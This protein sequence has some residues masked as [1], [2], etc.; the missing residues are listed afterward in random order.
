[1]FAS[2]LHSTPPY[3]LPTGSILESIPNQDLAPLIRDTSR[4]QIERLI[5]DFGLPV[6]T[7]CYECRLGANDDRVDL[8]ACLFPDAPDGPSSYAAIRRK[9][10][11]NP[12]WTRTLDLL[13]AWSTPG[14][15]LRARIPFIWIAFDLDRELA[16]LPSPCIGLCVDAGFFERRLHAGSARDGDPA[17]EGPTSAD[18]ELLADSFSRYFSGV[19]L[20]PTTK[21]LLH[22]CLRATGG[23]EPKHL[24]YML[25]RPAAPFKL[26]VR[27][28]L[29]RVGQY[30]HEIGWPAPALN[31]AKSIERLMPWSGHVQLNLVLQPRLSQP[32]EV[33]F[34]T[35][36]TEA[37]TDSRSSLLNSLVA[38]NLCSPEKAAVLLNL[39]E[40]PVGYVNGQPIARGWY[41][42]V[43]FMDDV[44]T[45]AKAYLG[46]MPRPNPVPS[47]D[48]A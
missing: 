10:A 28:P 32:L 31:V 48:L 29:D 15:P 21:A 46:L 1:M 40:R 24:S 42:K 26:D 35:L 41:V 17:A 18:L 25:G 6:Q 12:D 37:S 13:E 19:A 47:S 9:Y 7:A 30:L 39:H 5:Q 27:L 38:A 33:E 14:S 4:L 11:D 2:G 3:F 22:K 20:A 43:R 34:M 16:Q 45:E 36:A 44:A 8:A 23:V